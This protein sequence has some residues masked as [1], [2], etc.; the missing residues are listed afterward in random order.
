MVR[1]S[2]L[3]EPLD[4]SLAE[5]AR[6]LAHAIW[7]PCGPRAAGAVNEMVRR[8]HPAAEDGGSSDFR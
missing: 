3:R 5:D 4:E 2:L 6:V 1:T 8:R 7:V